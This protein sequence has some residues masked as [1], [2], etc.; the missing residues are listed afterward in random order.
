[1]NTTAWRRARKYCKMSWMVVVKEHA[2]EIHDYAFKK[3][4]RLRVSKLCHS[5]DR[6]GSMTFADCKS[7]EKT[8]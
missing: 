7:L 4:E 5:L 6:I 3:C 2:K 8:Q 1:L